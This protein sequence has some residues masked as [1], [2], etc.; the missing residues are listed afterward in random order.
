MSIGREYENRM[1]DN[2]QGL[3]VAIFAGVLTTMGEVMAEVAETTGDT[4][5]DGS[6]WALFFVIQNYPAIIL[7]V[8]LA[9]VT[10]S[11]GPFGIF[12]FLFEAA[13]ANVFFV[14]PI[15]GL[16]LFAIGAAIIVVGARL[17][18][19]LDLIGWFLNNRRRGR[20]KRYRRLR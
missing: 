10:L 5:V 2:I 8:A 11:A 13:G 7:L 14:N 9:A 16:V 15:V 1:F 3:F 6:I 12:G 18:S 17:W 19:W 4:T 20:N